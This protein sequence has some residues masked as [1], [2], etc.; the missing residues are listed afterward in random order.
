MRLGLRLYNQKKLRE[1]VHKTRI[2]V[3]KKT[4][5]VQYTRTE[6]DRLGYATVRL[7]GSPIARDL[8]IRWS[9]YRGFKMLADRL[10][11]TQT[12]MTRLSL[13]RF[14]WAKSDCERLRKIHW[15]VYRGCKM[16]ADRLHRTR[17]DT[18]RLSLC[19]FDWAEVRWRAH[20]WQ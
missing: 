2:I 13:C 5:H 8:E 18:T 1:Q 4:T 11:R 3:E 12:D 9:V 6:S 17:T 7:S 15:S 19:P 14:D 10:H 20:M 16:L